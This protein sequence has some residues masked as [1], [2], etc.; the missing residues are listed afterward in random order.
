MSPAAADPRW[1]AYA[2]RG[3][4]ASTYPAYWH[5]FSEAHVAAQ[6]DA[7]AAFSAGV[8]D[9]VVQHAGALAPAARRAAAAVALRLSR[10]AET[11][12]PWAQERALGALMR[13]AT[14]AALRAQDGAAVDALRAV[15][16]VLTHV[17]SEREPFFAVHWDGALDLLEMSGLAPL[18]GD[19]PAVPL[20]IAATL[21]RQG[22]ALPDYELRPKSQQARLIGVLGELLVY[23]E[24][25]DIAR[26]SWS[27][28]PPYDALL[29]LVV[30]A[31]R[32][33]IPGVEGI[34]VLAQRVF[35]AA[36]AGHPC[37]VT[38]TLDMLSSV[39]A[40]APSPEDGGAFAVAVVDR[41]AE[42]VMSLLDRYMDAET[43][44]PT[45]ACDELTTP[46]D[47]L[48]LPLLTV[49]GARVDA[50]DATCEAVERRF[51][52]PSVDGAAPTTPRIPQLAH[53][54][55][56]AH[57]PALSHLTG[58]LMYALSK[59]QGALLLRRFGIGPSAGIL[60]ALGVLGVDG[61]GDAGGA[62]V[63]VAGGGGEG[64]EVEEGTDTAD[65][66]AEAHAA[67]PPRDAT[68]S[69]DHVIALAQ[70]LNQLGV[71]SL[72]PLEQA[73]REGVLEEVE[74][75]MDDAA[76]RSAAEEDAEA[77]SAVDQWARAR[78]AKST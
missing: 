59:F 46:L 50:D 33:D 52:E 21:L 49:V 38:P 51:F 48:L 20:T 40:V 27:A 12:A 75:E 28:P 4:D 11:G 30:Q 14:P 68:L 8:R 45:R 60:E 57:F 17:P 62:G 69:D 74:R 66:D 72:N 15:C 1:T 29:A 44:A 25:A 76:R 73:A 22:A 70:R 5:S 43:G 55:S 39:L 34:H 65:A 3:P 18:D 26:G 41:A 10:S 9:D 37:P 36:K 19:G 31:C 53:L 56:S 35:V 6:A 64:G 47:A 24:P 67:P 63:Q 58:Y 42:L 78:G 23:L 61:D 54:M 77:E 7:A 32:G 16:N 71:M 13:F 2:A